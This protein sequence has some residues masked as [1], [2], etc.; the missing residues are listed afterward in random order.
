M[1]T[2]C[3]LNTMKNYKKKLIAIL[4]RAKAYQYN[5]QNYKIKFKFAKTNMNKASKR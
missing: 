5:A 1:K 3:L 2:L 4:K